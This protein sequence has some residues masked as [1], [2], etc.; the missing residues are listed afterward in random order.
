MNCKRRGWFFLSATL[1]LSLIALHGCVRSGVKMD[2]RQSAGE[3]QPVLA[4]ALTPGLS[5]AA[6][7]LRFNGDEA[8][9]SLLQQ[10]GQRVF[11]LQTTQAR[12]D[13]LP[14]NPRRIVEPLDAVQ[15]HTQSPLFDALNTLANHE[16]RECSV[17]AIR[18]GAYNH[19]EPVA[20]PAGGC[21][22]TGRKWPFVWTRD[23]AYA[24]ILGLGAVDPRRMMNSL[25][26][27]VSEERLPGGRSG[28]RYVVQDTGSGGGYPV[29]TDRVVWA[30]AAWELLKYLQGEERQ[31]FEDTAFE[32]IANTLEQDRHVAFD[33]QDGLYRGET[34]FLDWREQ[35]Y[36]PWTETNTTSIAQSRALSTN[37]LHMRALEVAAELAR[38]R[39]ENTLAE[40][41][42]GW[43]KALRGHIAEK[44]Y[45]SEE[46]LFAAT[47]ASPGDAP[48]R[49]FDLLGN[50]L[51]IEFE[52]ANRQQSTRILAA[53][54]WLPGGPPVVWPQSAT[55]AIYHNRATW[56]F[57]TGFVLR[58]AIKVGDSV[59]A[60]RAIESMVRGAALNLSN[61]EN[62]EVQSGLPNVDDGERSGPVVNSQRQLWSVAAFVGS[63]REQLFGF[64]AHANGD[65]MVDSYLPATTARWLFGNKRRIQL[66]GLM[67]RGR[68]LKIRLQAPETLPQEG[69]LEVRSV[70]LDTE[71]VDSQRIALSRLTPNSMLDVI[72]APSKSNQ[73]F[74]A[75]VRGSVHYAPPPLE[76]EKIAVV[77]N[78]AVLHF[79]TDL[80]AAT[81]M[82]VY[83][84]G[85]AVSQ[86][87]N[88][89]EKRW[90]DPKVLEG[91]AH[92]A[93][94]VVDLK[95]GATSYRSP[96]QRVGGPEMLRLSAQVLR[97]TQSQL[98]RTKAGDIDWASDRGDVL[99]SGVRVSES[100]TYA[101]RLLAANGN[102]P[103]NTGVTCGV[104]RATVENEASGEAVASATLSISQ[105]GSWD[106]WQLSTA[107]LAQLHKGQP[108]QVRITSD[109]YSKNMSYLRVAEL[110]TGGVGGAEGPLNRVHL[111]ELQITPEPR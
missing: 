13:D 22:E 82:R 87:S 27:K 7:R 69:A 107:L 29:S 30:W 3:G 12:R 86:E 99:W 49:K 91:V 80:P 97:P 58:A 14:E 96:V 111:R 60:Q 76:I 40:R 63:V 64:G 61:M 50:A 38:R 19:G 81:G 101:L 93:V 110:Y 6:D 55:A 57:V 74:S 94:E 109:A 36:A 100:G 72:L 45:L 65:V 11:V 8:Q 53:I 104:V 59:S 90:R 84:N 108:Y 79:L 67:Y 4:A 39:R 21:F 73:T 25:L 5:L 18:D 71:E 20:C 62:F 24:T 70:R 83:R 56:I 105:S 2:S 35:T 41:Y 89:H 26:F 103:V 15:T 23:T 48:A 68:T 43:A 17:E 9:A 46:G 16:G 10:D 77:E 51:A 85:V 98:Q 78:H 54:P 1:I 28:R 106:T 88:L 42:G 37:L 66:D 95:T 75:T 47:I 102:G 52:V 92:Y 34:S 44:F 33:P 32:V 31:I